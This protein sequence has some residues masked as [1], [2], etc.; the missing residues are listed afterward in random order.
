MSVDKQD[1]S[2]Y[3]GSGPLGLSS[4]RSQQA[5]NKVVRSDL[6]DFI[7]GVSPAM[8]TTRN[9]GTT[10]WPEMQA[11]VS[12]HKAVN[13][14]VVRVARGVGD[15]GR[16]WIVPEGGNVQETIA[17]ALAAMTLEGK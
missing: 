3:W 14:H 8:T 1:G 5:L 11:I 9:M 15:S 7:T 16:T 4:E 13:G 12:I 6:G 2:G 10:T 17:A